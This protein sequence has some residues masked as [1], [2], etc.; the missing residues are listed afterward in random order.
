MTRRLSA[1]LQT[2][3]APQALRERTARLDETAD[4]DLTIVVHDDSARCMGLLNAIAAPGPPASRMLI[5]S[6]TVGPRIAAALHGS[7]PAPS[8]LTVG[9][10]R[11]LSGTK[12]AQWREFAAHAGAAAVRL[13]AGGWDRVALGEDFGILG[14]VYFPATLFACDEIIVLARPARNVMSVWSGIAHPYS[15]LRANMAGERGVSELSLA[16]TAR[17]V[18]LLGQR[19]CS[20]VID[21]RD[22]VAAQVVAS[23]WQFV[24]SER[25]GYE[26][27][28][29]WERAETQHLTA[30]RAGVAIP[31]SLVLTA[32]A[33]RTDHVD[34]IER[35]AEIVG[36]RLRWEH[37]PHVQTLS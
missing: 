27:Q 1:I 16:L 12:L 29:P 26:S 8:S 37:A 10:P 35:L 18:L 21:T 23:A 36:C 7:L 25:D 3:R 15:M 24:Q 17:Y 9:L 19:G 11:G 32:A 13:D 4:A 2:A 6:T 5:A 34:R 22:R 28:G 20:A 33:A 30:L 31:S 14:Y